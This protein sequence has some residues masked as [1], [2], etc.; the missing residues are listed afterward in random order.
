MEESDD[1]ENSTDND[2]VSDDEENTGIQNCLEH[3]KKLENLQVSDFVYI[4]LKTNKSGN[5]TTKNHYM[6]QVV[7]IEEEEVEINT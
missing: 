2:D 1:E 4:G 5:F 6:G 3:L 7:T